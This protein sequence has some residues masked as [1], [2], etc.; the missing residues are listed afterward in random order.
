MARR[1]LHWCAL[2]AIAALTASLAVP[3]LAGATKG[4]AA[5]PRVKRTSLTAKATPGGVLLR[6][7]DLARDVASYDIYRSENAVTLG[8]KVNAEDLQGGTFRDATAKPG[9]EYFYTLKVTRRSSDAKK[10]SAA[11]RFVTDDESPKVSVRALGETIRP[12]RETRREQGSRP[13]A[14]EA[15]AARRG[16]S[17][18]RWLSTVVGADGPTTLTSDT[19]WDPAHGPYL[20]RNDVIIPEGKKL[21]IMPGTK[22]YFDFAMSG[23]L[24]SAL[25]TAAFADN[26]DPSRFIDLIVHGQLI[27]KGTSTNPITMTS[28]RSLSA[29]ATSDGL[30]EA[31]DWGHIFVDS[32]APS[33][34]SYANLEYFMGIWGQGTARPYLTNSKVREASYGVAAVHFEDPVYDAATPRMVI[35][36]N[37]IETAWGTG[38]SAEWTV[39]EGDA[40]DKEIDVLI[41]DNDITA[42]YPVFLGVYAGSGEPASYGNAYVK[43]TIKNN[44]LISP[45]YEGV[46]LDAESYEDKDAYVTTAFSNN[47]M[48]MSGDDG[49]YACAY[50]WDTGSAFCRPTF[51]GDRISA[52]GCGFYGEAYNRGANEASNTGVADATPTFTNCEIVGAGDDGVYLCATTAGSGEANSSGVFVGGSIESAGCEGVCSESYSYLGK[53]DAS[54]VFRDTTV[55]AHDACEGVYCYAYSD[56]GGTSTNPRF[57]RS[58]IK[59]AS[60]DGIYLYSRSGAGDAE[61]SPYLSETSVEGYYAGISAYAW[62]SDGGEGSGGSD[63][64]GQVVDSRIHAIYDDAYRAYSNTRGS[65]DAVASPV[66][67]RSTIEAGHDNGLVCEAFSAE[68]AATASPRIR[69]SQVTARQETLYCYARRDRTASTESVAAVVAPIVTNSFVSSGYYLPAYLEARNHGWAGSGRCN[70]VFTDSV[71][72]NGSDDY[73]LSC[74][75]STD[76][77]GTA[78]VQPSATRT[79]FESCYEAVYL[80][81]DGPGAAGDAKVGGAFTD[82]YLKSRYDSAAYLYS[83]DNQGGDTVVDTVFTRCDLE[84]PGD[85]G[86]EACS[87]TMWGDGKTSACAPVLT[88]CSVRSG[89]GIYCYAYSYRGGDTDARVAPRIVRT[90]IWSSWYWAVYTGASSQS[91]DALNEA[92]IERCPS[93]S[94]DGI[95]N[96]CWTEYDWWQ[97]PSFGGRGEAVNKARVIGRN[98]RNRTKL[99]S[100]NGYGVHNRAWSHDGPASDLSEVRYLDIDSNN[101]GVYSYSSCADWQ[102]DGAV[103]TSRPILNGNSIGTKWVND[104][105]GITVDSSTND[106]AVFA[107]AVSSNRIGGVFGDGISLL[108][109]ASNTITAAPYVTYNTIVLPRGSGMYIS[110]DSPNVSED[111]AVTVNR[112]V[113]SKPRFSGLYIESIPGGTVIGNRFRD[114]GWRFTSNSVWTTSGICWTSPDP[115]VALVKGNMVT[116]AK[117]SAVFYSNGGALTQYNSFGDA[118]GRYNAPFNYYTDVG[119]RG[120]AGDGGTP[121]DARYNWWGTTGSSNILDTIGTPN[122]SGPTADIVDPSS[123]LPTC[124]PRV[125][126]IGIRKYPTR[127]KFAVTFDRPMDTTIKTLYFGK[128]APYYDAYALTGTWSTDGKTFKGTY[129]PRSFLRTGVKMYFSGARD[130]PGNLMLST[131]KGFR[132]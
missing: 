69:D 58:E 117:S 106:E 97:D 40:G 55:I 11:S 80:E 121:Y 111:S 43:G 21:T 37:S 79:R 78:E 39:D 107:P 64:S 128:S 5:G 24:G 47:I 16:R 65:G 71:V 23:S 96:D 1:I 4:A 54:P 3:A 113:V 35:R 95:E 22:V 112:N 59:S 84:A 51:S 44:H 85:Y 61:A 99:E 91:G 73:G 89:N 56:E 70:P 46:Y 123:P 9:F 116:G 31:G 25:K 105:N 118:F 45:Q 100:T 108:A 72:R 12:E 115:D 92:H 29:S 19:V 28:I 98:L 129:W 131:S 2:I 120:G 94:Y 76:G 124:Q 8:E 26:D 6:P 15:R 122:H 104:G 34:I 53:A 66:I 86:L 90:P 27:A 50:A 74:Y 10:G 132:L 7:R 109:S 20:V 81:A 42:D 75:A 114:P 126:S 88:D 33:E 101:S 36:G 41:D 119:D 13:S 17:A 103:L 57:E 67:A 102:G 68:G 127:V 14:P 77:T 93:V 83:T 52:S 18:V 82:C 60:D 49:V 87:F 32:R 110:V 38:V 125:S 48:S 130:L 30:P 62:G 63:C